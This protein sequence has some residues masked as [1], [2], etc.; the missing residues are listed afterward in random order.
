VSQTVDSAVV[1]AVDDLMVIREGRT[2]LSVPRLRIEEHQRW[3]LLGPNGSGKSTLLSVISGRLW[4]TS[5]DVSIFGHRFG[6][7]DLRTLRSRLGILS[8]A[9]TRQLHPGLL[10]HDA[11]VT[12]IDGALEPWWRDY[13]SAI[14]ARAD[15]L[16]DEL[17]IGH[18]SS[19]P[20][21]VISEG[22]RAQV[23]LARVLIAQP[24]LICLDEPAAG[25]DLGARER[26]LSR[27]GA[28]L[29]SANPAPFVMVTHHLEELAVG[30]THATLLRE[31]APLAIGPLDEVITSEL[32]SEAFNVTVEIRRSSTGRFAIRHGD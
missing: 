13:D 2:I 31:G 24:E 21:G 10:V 22:E 18:L 17:G 6:Q 4:P 1:V 3:A 16:L 23:L 11:V 8:S 15:A 30:L 26:L 12:G 20:I 28:I 25:L 32:V 14:H 19:K 27:L 29:R 9:I 7:V 5:G